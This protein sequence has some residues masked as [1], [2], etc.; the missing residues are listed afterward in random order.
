MNAV[1]LPL[2][3]L[4]SV[5]LLELLRDSAS[6]AFWL[7]LAYRLPSGI[8]DSTARDAWLATSASNP[9]L[10]MRLEVGRGGAWQVIGK[11]YE[12]EILD[13]TETASG[14]TLRKWVLVE[15]ERLKLSGFSR[16]QRPVLLRGY[17]GADALVWLH[18]HI[19]ID[20]VSQ[21]HVLKDF[22]SLLHDPTTHLSTRPSA[23]DVLDWTAQVKTIEQARAF[24]AAELAGLP[25]S[26]LLDFRKPTRCD[27]NDAPDLR[28][29]DFT[30]SANSAE[31]LH[32]Y[33][34]EHR[35]TGA[36]VITQLWALIV[37]Q[38]SSG[39]ELC[40]GMTF[41]NRPYQV[42]AAS[43][44]SGMLINTLP[45][46]IPLA[47][48][49]R[50]SENCRRTLGTILRVSEHAHVPY[51]DL[52]E[53]AG[54]PGLTELYSTTVIVEN[55]GGHLDDL[56][57]AGGEGPE[58]LLGIGTSPD[59]LGLTV[60]VRDA[61]IRVRL[62]WD[63]HR[64]PGEFVVRLVEALESAVE[65]LAEL[66]EV[67]LRGCV[68]EAPTQ[69]ELRRRSLPTL[70]SE[71]QP[72]SIGQ[73]LSRLNPASIALRDDRTVL[74]YGE[75]INR[76]TAV[77]DALASRGVSKGD[78]VALV[79]ARCVE[80]P[81]AM[82]AVWLRGASWC[83]VDASLPPA[84]RQHIL[85]SFDPSV[86]LDLSELDSLVVGGYPAVDHEDLL[87]AQ[88]VAYV[89]ATSGSTG[90]PKLVAVAAGGLAPLV[91]AWH[92]FYRL[93]D[94]AHN[95]LQLGAWSSDVFLGDFLKA[96]STGGQLIIASDERRVDFEYLT[97]LI[98]AHEVCLAESTP[99]LILAVLRH[100]NDVGEC[101]PSLHTLIVGADLFRTA[102]LEEALSLLWPGVKLYNG[103]GLTE[104]TV[105]SIVFACDTAHMS[106]SGLCPIGNA[107]PGTAVRLID[108]SGS[109]VAV[110]AIGNLLI[111]GPGVMAGYLNSDG[112]ID[113]SRITEFEGIRYFHT[114]DRAQLGL[115]G[116]IEFFG[117]GDDLVKIRGHRIELGEIENLLLSGSS[118][119]EAFACVA[120]DGAA[121]SVV[122]FVSGEGIDVTELLSVAKSELPEFAVPAHI[123][124]SRQLPRNANGKI[125]K[126]VLLDRA[127]V[128]MCD[129]ASE[130]I[131][132]NRASVDDLT[133]RMRSVWQLVLH[134]PVDEN[135]SFFDQGGN[136]LLVVSLL[137]QLRE[138]LPEHT[139]TV[140][141]LFRH[142]SI[143]ALAIHLRGAANAVDPPLV[144]SGDHAS[145]RLAVLR[146][147]QEN[148][149]T[150]ADALRMLGA[151]GGLAGE[152]D[153]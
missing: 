75:L 93:G 58:L 12:L 47:Q 108:E 60:D 105:E 134:S 25:P 39:S 88:D 141:D 45:V 123:W 7:A 49:L 111:G 100:L 26:D 103:Y 22:F 86:V 32:A 124:V 142:R 133:E 109:D 34:T 65:R 146:A 122:V 17:N 91:D 132:E 74:T 44:A 130:A 59:P 150:E 57:S 53:A 127:A 97:T 41:A 38:Y 106:A 56:G 29:R 19:L 82:A 118:V 147:L 114:G 95:V 87:A 125:D 136:S 35:V 110:G 51:S 117:R 113:D 121:A 54:L 152:H 27:A 115:D 31:S 120:G 69:A 148:K 13:W 101:P 20:G 90:Y 30:F 153:L 4:Q 61:E 99:A 6:D 10:R 9:A 140:P 126:P 15:T 81:V 24:W 149:L 94:R 85:D 151:A 129:T 139:I 143:A 145:N 102:E 138:A 52:I 37:G 67:G 55:F 135:R 128:L 92:D 48:D 5:M 64:Y 79:G 68:I 137:E 43:E 11:P 107:L 83:P 89:V 116:V 1:K 14:R 66:E 70:V 62:G 76:A 40:V 18:H 119:E 98:R 8:S 72:W 78:R 16:L 63:E 112:D 46:R 3:P 80:A 28:V 77:A 23:V 21:A 144:E 36:G 104:C 131:P 2:A 73:R 71:A 33:S 42:P 96:M 84:R 50:L